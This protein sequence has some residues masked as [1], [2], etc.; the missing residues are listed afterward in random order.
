VKDF[1]PPA[2]EEVRGEGC[3]KGATAAS[4]GAGGPWRGRMTQAEEPEDDEG[5]GGQQS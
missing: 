2:I 5:G 1:S 4:G 3:G